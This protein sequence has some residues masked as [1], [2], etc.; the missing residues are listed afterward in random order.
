LDKALAADKKRLDDLVSLE[1]RSHADAPGKIV[2][3]ADEYR[4]L[5]NKGKLDFGPFTLAQVKEQISRD[6]IVPGNILIDMEAGTRA[7]VVAHPL[8]RDIVLAAAHMRD[9]RRRA[10]V[11]ATVVKQEKRRG[12]AL[13]VFLAAGAAALA[14][15]AYV[16]FSVL[17][18][19]QTAAA[20]QH[21]E[22]IASAALGGIKFGRAKAVDDRDAQRKHRGGGRHGGARPAAG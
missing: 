5:V 21:T 4:W 22:L 9:D 20:S 1:Q 3:P 13:S 11:E 17:K 14:V 6:E 16:V 8:L 2:V 19:G 10:H 15:G 18:V 7:D 12:W